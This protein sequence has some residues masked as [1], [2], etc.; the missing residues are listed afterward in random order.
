M[1]YN[2][3]YALFIGFGF[4]VVAGCLFGNYIATKEVTDVQ[5]DQTQEINNLRMELSN[6]KM[7]YENTVERYADI[8]GANKIM[9]KEPG[10][11]EDDD[12]EEDSSFG[13]REIS[14]EEAEN[15]WD[16]NRSAVLTY[17]QG[18]GVL[19]DTMDEKISDIAK[20]LGDD[21]VEDIDTTTKDVLYVKNDYKDCIYEVMIEHNL[22]YYKDVLGLE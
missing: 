16:E 21:V 9:N 12:D 1:D 22:E 11:T 2:Y 3:I 19:A 6:A 10:P 4:G 18:D 20:Y 7:K 15:E 14:P 13:I 8:S 17:Y 5:K